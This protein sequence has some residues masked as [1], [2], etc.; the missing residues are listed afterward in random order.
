MRKLRI[1]IVWVDPNTKKGKKGL[2]GLKRLHSEI[3][4]NELEVAEE[5]EVSS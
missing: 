2:C 4:N 3:E 5:K 1:N